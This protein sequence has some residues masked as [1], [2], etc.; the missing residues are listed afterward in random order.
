M[1]FYAEIYRPI[2]HKKFFILLVL[3][4]LTNTTN[5]GG[6]C[7][8]TDPTKRTYRDGDKSCDLCLPGQFKVATCSNSL[9]TRCA[10]CPMNTYMPFYN[11]CEDCWICANL[12]N[13]LHQI[14]TQEC[15]GTHRR[16]CGCDVGT[17]MLASGDRCVRHSCPA[18]QRV[19]VRGQ[20]GTDIR[21]RPCLPHSYSDTINSRV[22]C[23]P[24]TNCTT[25]GRDYDWMGNATHNAKCRDREFGGYNTTVQPNVKQSVHSVDNADSADSEMSDREITGNSKDTTVTE[26]S[27]Y[28]GNRITPYPS[29]PNSTNQHSTDQGLTNIA[30]GLFV[31][32]GVIIMVC[33]SCLCVHCKNGKKS[34][35]RKCS[36]SRKA[37][38]R[39]SF[40]CLLQ[41]N[42]IL[43]PDHKP[44]KLLN[45]IA[46]GILTKYHKKFLRNLPS[47]G[48][49]D[50]EIDNVEYCKY[51]LCE[52]VYK[53][54][55]C[56][57]KKFSTECFPLKELLGVLKEY[58]DKL[59]RRLFDEHCTIEGVTNITCT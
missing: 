30:I 8:K 36:I 18:G 12:C 55:V 13:G 15:N 35:R 5:G 40:Q 20:A 48:L 6:K 27:T 38:R 16:E 51:D 31:A 46:N 44:E 57:K 39:C 54:L 26:D 42:V 10:E 47:P 1:S 21:C 58:D 43:K 33:L 45:G 34:P 11:E 4:S 41:Q 2:L 7:Y 24:H 49:T 32:T 23:I 17:Y 37:K 53:C 3:L 28:S 22:S 56:W 52:T 50:T 9:G 25:I 29:S 14:T 19:H 59:S